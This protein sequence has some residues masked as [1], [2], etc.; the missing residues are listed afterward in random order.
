MIPISNTALQ[1]LAQTFQIAPDTLAHFGG[2]REDSDGIVYAYPFGDAR[3]LLKILAFPEADSRRGLFCLDER[4]RFMRFLGENGAAVAYPLP[5][6]EGNLYET[7]PAE[8]HLWVAYSMDIA[9]GQSL[10]FH[11]WDKALFRGWGQA[12]GRMHR[13]AQQYPSWETSVDPETGQP[14][15]NWH[16]EW[17]GFYNW[18]QDD[19]VRQKWVEIGKRLKTLPRTRSDF[20]FVHNDPHIANLLANDEHVTMIDFDVANHHWFISDIA[21]ACQS[22]L[23]THSGGMERP[24]ENREKLMTFFQC[25]FE[26][27]ERENR[28]ARFW[29]EQLDL[30]IA[31][32]RI[33]LFIVMYGWIQSQPETH[34]SW[35]K[36][37][38]E[39]PEIVGD[40]VAHARRVRYQA[41]I[42]QNGR[43]LLVQHRNHEDGRSYWLLPGGGREVGE[44]EEECIQREMREETGLE[45]RVERLLWSKS[46]VET[47]SPRRTYWCTPIAG[48]AQPGYEPEPEV[49]AIY[50]IAAVRWLDLTDES[51]WGEE[52]IS[53]RYTYTEL[54]GLQIVWSDCS[55]LQPKA[56]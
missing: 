49:A 3:R 25:F 36:M 19:E 24:L 21:I 27:Y 52:I 5:S 10:P 1:A 41:A 12:V 32:R 35:K 46:P 26:G 8:G 39:S 22:I 56:R 14:N 7:H 6:P 54:K 55:A 9:P 16:E 23:F 11:A 33:L 20:G 18:F 45:V 4:L 29:L 40:E 30:F 47:H 51:T 15:L 17:E 34:A 44:T 37:I 38:L 48:E 31:Y 53:D 2:G 28:L 42:I 50:A 43:V 13:L